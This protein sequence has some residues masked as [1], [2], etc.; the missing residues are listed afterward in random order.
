MALATTSASSITNS[1]TTITS[2]PKTTKKLTSWAQAAARSAPAYVKKDE[3]QVESKVAKVIDTTDSNFTPKKKASTP[4][5]N[6]NLNIS[7]SNNNNGTNSGGN[8]SNKKH[9][10]R[11][12]FNRNEVR[13]YMND[14]FIKYEKDSKTLSYQNVVRNNKSLPNGSWDIVQSKSN[15]HRNKKYGLLIEVAKLLK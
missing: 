12:P 6:I 13:S 5:G 14:L 11:Q 9:F 3:K 8:T 1:S 4:N 2:T 15:R 7:T 10:N